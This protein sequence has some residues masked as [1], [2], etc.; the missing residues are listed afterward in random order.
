MIDLAPSL[1]R[2][3]AGTG[4]GARAVRPAPLATDVHQHLWPEGLLGA[5]AARRAAPRLARAGT[6]WELHAD[7]E[8]VCAVDPARHD[9]VRR[10]EY[11]RRDGLERIIIAPSCPI[12]VETLPAREAEPLLA[13]YHVGVAEL[14]E[15]FR[16]WAA[17][18][19]D[20]PDV[21]LLAAHL[22]AGFVGLCIP[23]AALCAPAEIGRLAP[24]LEV[25]DARSAPLLIHPGPAPWVP[26]PPV[27]AHAP[28]WWAALTTYVAQMQ[29]AWFVVHRFVRPDFPALRICFAMLAGLAP[30]QSDRLR[31]RG[32]QPL[33]SDDAT[34]LETSSY[35][36]DLAA[37]IAAVVGDR[38]IVFGSDRPVVDTAPAP[39][40]ATI[41]RANASRL[42]DTEVGE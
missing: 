5:L 31:S 3:H 26:G 11:A 38:A 41:A 18:S 21:A 25:L 40:S 14:G 22:D 7:G 36:P 2:P 29:Q 10:A 8:P 30:L 28:G 4:Q 33:G 37:A 9:P 20:A 17:T 24:L 1:D 6:G 16:A 12:G 35:G 23:A 42:I 39:A 19:L 27:P 32:A 34:F 15:P 13:A